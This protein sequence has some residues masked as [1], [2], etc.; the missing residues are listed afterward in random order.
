MS[1]GVFNLEKIKAEKWCLCNLVHRS[2]TM[3]EEKQT[4][5]DA[6][7]QGSISFLPIF[8]EQADVWKCTRQEHKK[9]NTFIDCVRWEN[10]FQNKLESSLPKKPTWIGIAKLT[11]QGMGHK[12]TKIGM[13]FCFG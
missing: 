12:Q 2:K 8:A 9:I 11:K 3:S 5:V 4:S 1:T 7:N 10:I 13:L 6:I